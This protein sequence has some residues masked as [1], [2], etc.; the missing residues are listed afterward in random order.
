MA[1][2]LNAIGIH[3]FVLVY[4]VGPRYR[5]PAML[6]DVSRAIRTVRANAAEWKIDPARVGVIG[7]SAG[8]HLAL[9]S[10][11]GWG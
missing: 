4:R 7:F 11:Q 10:A 1:K 2:W 3:A 8:G 6:Q 5:H 9:W